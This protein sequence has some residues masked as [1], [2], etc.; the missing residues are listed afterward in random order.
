MSWHST[1]VSTTGSEKGKPATSRRE[2]ADRATSGGACCIELLTLSPIPRTRR[3]PR[4]GGTSTRMPQIFR[5]ETYTSF[6]HFRPTSKPGWSCC[7]ACPTAS[8]AVS[9]IR[10]Q[11]ASSRLARS[12][13][14]SEKVRAPG[15]AHQRCAPRPRPAVCISVKTKAG[16]ARDSSSA[17]A[18][19]GCW[20]KAGAG[21][22]PAR[23]SR[24]PV[25]SARDPPFRTPLFPH[26]YSRRTLS[27]L[28]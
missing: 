12:G 14:T 22:I 25:G 17:Q 10:G 8:P 7:S 1:R 24:R 6:G 9:A 18:R 20:S 27:A 13:S 16:N 21:G 26:P 15:A 2:I 11:L 5:S 28:S 19:H 3:S 4:R 23:R